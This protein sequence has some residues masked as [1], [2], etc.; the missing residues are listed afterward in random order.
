MIAGI[1]SFL[2]G[3]IGRLVVGAL[4]IGGAWLWVKTHYEAKGAAKEVAKI[5]EAGAK[6]ARTAA[7][8]RAKV[9]LIPDSELRDHYFRAD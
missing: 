1:I 5:V 4:V 8:I 9:K 3:T 7:K 6:N 2:S